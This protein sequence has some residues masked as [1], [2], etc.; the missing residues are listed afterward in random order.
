MTKYS[1]YLF[2]KF[3]KLLHIFPTKL[4]VY[5]LLYNHLEFCYFLTKNIISFK[6]LALDWFI[7]R[8]AVINKLV[9]EGEEELSLF[10]SGEGIN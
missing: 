10:Q 8:S 1:G 9:P 4:K 2:E 5:L 7:F 3:K 6:Q